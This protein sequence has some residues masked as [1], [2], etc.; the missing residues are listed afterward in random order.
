M[1]DFG[2]LVSQMLGQQ[3]FSPVK[4]KL[5]YL[6]SLVRISWY[7][8]IMA[9]RSQGYTLLPNTLEKISLT[10]HPAVHSKPTQND[11]ILCKS[12]P[13][14]PQ[15]RQVI[16]K[17]LQDNMTVEK[18]YCWN[19]EEEESPSQTA[20]LMNINTSHLAALI[21]IFFWAAHAFISVS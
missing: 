2:I 19:W 7:V 12:V 5:L 8:T 14:H 13:R 16:K 15:Y 3:I 21:T 18:R 10:H 9:F 4:C 6:Q 1:Q 17:C 11:T 20:H